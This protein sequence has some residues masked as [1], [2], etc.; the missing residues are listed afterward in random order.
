MKQNW[1]LA[2]RGRQKTHCCRAFF[3]HPKFDIAPEK[4]DGW[5]TSFNFRGVHM[6]ICDT[7]C[8]R[9]VFGCWFFPRKR[10]VFGVRFFFPNEII[11]SWG[12]EVG[13]D[14]DIHASGYTRKIV[15][16]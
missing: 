13:F 8:R 6:E 7:F 9:T 14:V 12:G 2:S 1:I 11:S 15:L 10:D 16:R 4:W 5:K 3:T